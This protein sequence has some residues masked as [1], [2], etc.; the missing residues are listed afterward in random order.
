MPPLDR[1]LADVA[2]AAEDL[3]RLLGDP[4]RLPPALSFDI[5]P[6][7]LS[8]GLPVGP[9]HAA[10]H[11][12]SREASSSVFMSASLKAIDWFSMI[13]RPNWPRSLAYS[14]AYS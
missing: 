13:G 11:T 14:R 10:R 6:S 2:V 1:V 8:N 9:I 5:E 3:D 4:H 7:P 12:S